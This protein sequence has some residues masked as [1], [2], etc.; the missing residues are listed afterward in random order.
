MEE[1]KTIVFR[2]GEETRHIIEKIDDSII[3]SSLFSD[4]YKK[5]LYSLD[6]ICRQRRNGALEGDN[7]DNNIISFIGD[8]GSGKTSCMVSFSNLLRIGLKGELKV[9]YPSVAKTEFHCVRRIDPS[10]FDKSHNVIEL[11]LANLYNDFSEFREKV[12]ASSETDTQERI[13]LELFAESQKK[14]SEM[15]K[16]QDD[17]YDVL[18]KLQNLSAGVKLGGVIRELV[19]AFMEYI[20]KRGGILV[21]QIDDIDLNSSMAAEMMEQIRK[22]LIQPN[23]VILLAA[24]LDQLSSAKE[25]QLREEFSA[26]PKANGQDDEF[27]EMVDAYLTKLLPHQQR[28]YMPDGIAYFYQPVVVVREFGNED[29]YPSVRQMIPELI[30]KKTRYLFYNSPDRTS[31]IV[32][33]NL[34]D[35]RFLVSLLYNMQ[36]YWRRPEEDKHRESNRYNKL[37]F[38]KYLYENWAPNNLDSSMQKM[39]KRILEIQDTEQVNAVVVACLK[40]VFKGALGSTQRVRP[41]ISQ[42]EIELFEYDLDST[43]AQLDQWCAE[44]DFVFNLAGVNRP[45]DVKEF[46][47]GNF[48]FASTLLNTLRKHENNCPVMLSSS[49]QASLTGR[50]GDSEY[51]RSKKAGGDL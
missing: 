11:F 7:T 48:G 6:Y 14:M 47:S 12:E 39:V 10:F 13:V 29:R 41:R 36:D 25:I 42:N 16:A 51:G 45:K 31:Y 49:Q 8:R 28:V 21:L 27:E 43:P 18:E 1:L 15:T 19:Q 46:M 38:R 9:A 32:P 26:L 37:L 23:I 44:A 3:E 50:F 20:N 34:R 33:D 22:F 30:F 40:D 35:L 24:K 5:A 4:Q 2:L 17:G